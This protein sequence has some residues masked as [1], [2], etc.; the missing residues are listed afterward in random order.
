MITKFSAL[1]VGQIELDNVGLHGTPA[2]ER[3]YPNE[4]LVEA[5]QTAKDVAQHMDELGYYA[6]WTAEH[7]FQHEGYE[8]FPNLILLGTWLAT[9]TQRLKFGC[10]FNVLPMWHPIRLA[11]D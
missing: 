1:Y 4:R 6:L 11:E 7:H 2:D 9:Q 8:V 3:R 5:F 10:A